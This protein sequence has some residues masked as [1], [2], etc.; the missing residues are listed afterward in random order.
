[1]ISGEKILLEGTTAITGVYPGETI[2]GLRCTGKGSVLRLVEGLIPASGKAIH[3]IT[4]SGIG[5]QLRQYL[6]ILDFDQQRIDFIMNTAGNSDLHYTE[7][8]V[9]FQVVSLGPKTI[10]KLQTEDVERLMRE[11]I[12]V[13]DFNRMFPR[14]PGSRAVN[15]TLFF[16]SHYWKLQHDVT[17]MDHLGAQFRGFILANGQV[18]N[19]IPSGLKR[20]KLANVHGNDLYV[21]DAFNSGVALRDQHQMILEFCPGYQLEHIRY[22]NRITGKFPPSGFKSLLQKLIRYQPINVNLNE[23]IFSAEFTALATFVALLNHPGAFVPNIQ[24][25]VTGKESAIKRL[26]VSIVED[27]YL[28]P[29]FQSWIPIL[30]LSAL[31]AQRH[32]E[33]QPTA[34][35]IKAWMAII[36]QALRERRAFAYD[37]STEIPSWTYQEAITHPLKLASYLLDDLRSFK[38]DLWM[39]RSLTGANRSTVNQS[40]R[41]DLMRLDHCVDQH[42][43]P[44]I[45]L[46]VSYQTVLDNPGTTGEPFKGLFSKLFRQVTGINSRYQTV[47]VTPFVA[48]IQRAQQLVFQAKFGTRIPLELPVVAS[49]HFRTDVNQSWVAA[50]VG[51]VSIG[52]YLVTL[53]PDDLYLMHA[54]VKPGRNMKSAILTDEEEAW[55]IEQMKIKLSQGVPMEACRS[56]IGKAILKLVDGQYQVIKGPYQLSIRQALTV[57]TLFEEI[58]MD[59]PDWPMTITYSSKYFNRDFSIGDILE[60]YPRSVWQRVVYY[61]NGYKS[62]IVINKIGLSGGSNGLM[63]TSE[64]TA[65]F[66]ILARIALN[67]P[68]TL[69]MVEGKT[70]TFQVNSVIRLFWLADDIRQMIN[71]P[72]EAEWP[73]PVDSLNRTPWPHQLESLEEMKDRERGNFIWIPVGMGKTWI[74]LSYL[75]YLISE[76]RLPAHVIYTLPDSAI[77]SIIREIQVFGFEVELMH[78]VNRPVQVDIPVV[79][80]PTAGRI[81]LIEHDHLRLARSSL[82]EVVSQS[83]FVV[84]EVHL[85]LNDTQRTGV[86]L[87]LSRLSD[88]FIALTGTP[89]IDTKIYKLQHWLEQIADYEVTEKN[90]W[91]AVNSMIA[92]KVNTGVIVDQYEVLAPFTELENG[93]Y[94]SKV[95]VKHGGNNQYPKPED[96][97]QAMTI[98]YEAIT[99][100]MV[101]QTALLTSGGHRC[102]VVARDQTHAE[103]LYQ[104]I[105]RHLPANQIYLIGRGSSIFLTHQTTGPEADI[106][107]VITPIRRSSGYTVTLMNIM[108]T[109]VYPSNNATRQQ[110]EGRINRISQPNPRISQIT[111]HAGVATHMMLY[112]KDAKNLND[113]LNTMADDITV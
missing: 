109:S 106:R 8:N 108:I 49:R 5:P 102:F 73:T 90:F 14:K 53:D 66:Q 87:E 19:T 83:M 89:V 33:W 7:C 74:V 24:R 91:V 36:L 58:E 30:M 59:P 80:T 28:A 64:D 44:E 6:E 17:D 16:G 46:Y 54:I 68:N 56:P 32:A 41:P 98:S 4:S 96:Y 81:T 3:A 26:G 99:R 31:V 77:N 18:T 75:A 84:D 105:N 2:I 111:V 40:D 92:K 23:T 88:N 67:L 25:Y 61:L 82:M 43:A 11:P 110:I 42:W 21:F 65:A 55:A 100:E 47:Q 113:V 15:H 103:E 38:G 78:P 60:E 10:E 107:V 72:S 93:N 27:S 62:K 39:F 51:A 85:T 22:F 112:H 76:Q 45:G 29:E 57:S 34:E 37:C 48:D 69:T 20:M 12:S 70:T 104:L 95:S 52:N 50:L 35:M 79:A 1:M 9:V 94:R 71:L 97:R 86:A 13:Q 101:N 63:V